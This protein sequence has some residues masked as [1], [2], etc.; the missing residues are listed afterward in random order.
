M[1]FTKLVKIMETKGNKILWNIKTMRISMISLI[2]C[3]LYEYH[4][5]FMK[6]A[7]DALSITFPKYN[8]CLLTYVKS[9]LG[10][11]VI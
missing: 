3:V 4:T 6:M 1:E 11:N 5:L 9:L 8:M 7:L 2:K 10:F